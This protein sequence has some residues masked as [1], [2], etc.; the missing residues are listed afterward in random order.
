MGIADS[1]CLWV[2]V[3]TFVVACGCERDM[4]LSDT[5]A[6]E[7]INQHF[8]P[9]LGRTLQIER[10]THAMRHMGK[11]DTYRLMYTV[12]PTEFA[13]LKTALITKLATEGWRV[14]DD[15][16]LYTQPASLGAPEW[17]KPEELPDP[18]VLKAI[19]HSPA[20][21]WGIWLAYSQET[22]TAYLCIWHT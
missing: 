5:Q 10:V 13:A 8:E 22:R 16:V 21:H 12:A 6:R 18:D 17:W 14:D 3:V 9:R 20:R 1:V 11:D 7:L 19:R 15:D 2:L 4:V